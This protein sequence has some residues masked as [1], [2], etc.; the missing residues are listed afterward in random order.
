MTGLSNLASVAIKVET[1]PHPPATTTLGSAVDLWL[2]SQ[3][4]P[5]VPVRWWPQ[6]GGHTAVSSVEQLAGLVAR[7]LPA[8]G[9][10]GV[11]ERVLTGA[12]AQTMRIPHGW[13]IEVDGGPGPNAFAQRVQRTSRCVAGVRQRCT[14]AE[15]GRAATYFTTEVIG[16]PSDAARIMWAWLRG[17]LPPGYEL[18][19]IVNGVD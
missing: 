4:L 18:R 14:N 1:D 5:D 10:W 12:W 7:L 3:E 8:L 2:H 6:C 19:A 16:S 13:I 9:S 15:G 11:A 17:R